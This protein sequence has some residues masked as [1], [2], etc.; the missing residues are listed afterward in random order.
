MSHSSSDLSDEAIAKFRANLDVYPP[1]VREGALLKYILGLTRCLPGALLHVPNVQVTLPDQLL[2]IRFMATKHL[3]YSMVPTNCMIVLLFPRTF[4]A[5][6]PCIF[7]LE[8]PID[9]SREHQTPN[10]L[11]YYYVFLPHHFPTIYSNFFDIE[12]YK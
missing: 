9:T 6:S 11:A 5:V 10:K 12:V 8:E 1:S 2:V 4:T 7:R 3:I